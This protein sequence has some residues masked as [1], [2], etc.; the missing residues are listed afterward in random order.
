MANNFGPL[1]AIIYFH[2]FNIGRRVSSAVQITF[3]TLMLYRISL[4]INY[5][6]QF[7]VECSLI[8]EYLSILKQYIPKNCI[9][10]IM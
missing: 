2:P 7:N 6:H 3:I 9:T 10:R 8:K 4:D 1:K 5:L